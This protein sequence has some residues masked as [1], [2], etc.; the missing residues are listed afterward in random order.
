MRSQA[1]TVWRLYLCARRHQSIPWSTPSS[2]KCLQKSPFEIVALSFAGNSLLD[3]HSRRQSRSRFLWLIT[4]AEQFCSE[5]LKKT[6][7]SNPQKVQVICRENN[8]SSHS[9]KRWMI[10][11][12]W[13]LHTLTS[14]PN[15][16]FYLEKISVRGFECGV[17]TDW[18][19]RIGHSMFWFLFPRNRKNFE[20]VVA[21]SSY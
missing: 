13:D 16:V 17:R 4:A 9:Q 15:I 21:A 5:N 14:R 6:I 20:T 19:K 7:G 12:P 11:D 8:P 2:C 18:R 10:F 3:E 1:S